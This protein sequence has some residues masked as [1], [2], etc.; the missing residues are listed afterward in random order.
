MFGVNAVYTGGRGNSTHYFKLEKE[1]KN[2][3]DL[4]RIE[5]QEKEML[6]KLGWIFKN[7][8][9]DFSTSVDKSLRYLDKIV[10]PIIMASKED[11]S[12]NPFSE[13]IEK[14][15][16]HILI[17]KF[18]KEGY[19]LL[20]LGYSADLTLEND[21]YILN[22]DVKTANIDNPSDFKETVNVGINQMTHVAKLRLKK[23]K[24]LL[25]PY[26]VY[27]NIPPFYEIGDGNRKLILTYGLMFIY[28]SYHDLID[29]IREDYQDLF[30]FFNQKLKKSLIPVIKSNFNVSKDVEAKKIIEERPKRSRYSKDELITESLI[31]GVFIHRQEKED[32]LKSLEISEE[33]I[34]NFSNH[35]KECINQLRERDIKPI[36]IIAISIPN[37]L[38]KEKYLDKFV[39]G[40][41][42]AR[43]ARYHY[44]DGVFEIIKEKTGEK[45]PRVIFVDLN[46]NYL[47]NLKNYFDKIF[48]LDYKLRRI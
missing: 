46:P 28:P 18:E 40:K 13:I 15:V 43:S 17:H 24:F 19:S 44:E 37:G 45:L 42:Y 5:E 41:D 26:F 12:Y 39:S 47:N 38:L 23:R 20:P 8:L 35:L 21:Q 16:L 31:R 1:V 4:K 2:M 29:K 33:D 9:K 48:V 27:P 7:S 10:L 32:I 14:Y 6:F 11:K 30:N 34:T 3:D 36:A 22:I 25:P